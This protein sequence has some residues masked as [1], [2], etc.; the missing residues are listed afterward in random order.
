[1]PSVVLVSVTHVSKAMV[2]FSTESQSSSQVE[3]ART[4]F[5]DIFPRLEKFRLYLRNSVVTFQAV[6][7]S[8]GRFSPERACIVAVAVAVAVQFAVCSCRPCFSKPYVVNT[9]LSHN[10]LCSYCERA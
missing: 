5:I 4:L 8:E 3:V 2:S 9:L 7:R 10:S 6:M 1:M